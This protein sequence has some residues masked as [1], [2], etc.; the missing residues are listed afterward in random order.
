M[1][2]LITIV[3]PLHGIPPNCGFGF[4]HSLVRI[5]MPLKTLVQRLQLPQ[6]LQPPSTKFK[7]HLSAEGKCCPSMK[8]KQ[9]HINCC[10]SAIK[11]QLEIK[12]KSR[13]DVSYATTDFSA[14]SVGSD[15]KL[16]GCLC[17]III[18]QLKVSGYYRQG[19][20]RAFHVFSKNNLFPSP[21]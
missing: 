21:S 6:S 8:D 16:L 20:W 12:R 13:L 4:T 18:L 1:H 19:A 2:P 9:Y 5:C 17:I 7:K 3:D 15:L 10:S 14:R 11:A